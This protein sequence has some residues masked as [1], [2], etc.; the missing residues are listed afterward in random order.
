MILD[1]F[2]ELLTIGADVSQ[3]VNLSKN[4]ADEKL[5]KKILLN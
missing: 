2:F 5:F 3:F 4:I 1:N